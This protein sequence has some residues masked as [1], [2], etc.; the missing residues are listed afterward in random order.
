MKLDYRQLRYVASCSVAFM[1]GILSFAFFWAITS[2]TVG[3]VLMAS[4]IFC[5][6]AACVMFGIT[7]DTKPKKKKV[8]R[9]YKVPFYT[10]PKE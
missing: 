2:W 7:Y 5:V 4:L 1:V 3:Y 8:T 9:E 10:F 6:A